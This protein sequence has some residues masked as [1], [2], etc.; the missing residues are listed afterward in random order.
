LQLPRALVIPS[1]W[2]EVAQ[3]VLVVVQLQE[4]LA[5]T[6]CLALLPVTVVAGAD[7]VAPAVAAADR[8]LMA[9]LVV[10]VV[11]EVVVSAMQVQ[12]ILLL[13]HPVKVTMVEQVQQTPQVVQVVVV[14]VLWVL[15]LLQLVE[16]TE[17]TVRLVA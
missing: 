9:W 1:Q 3:P 8:V 12:A 11:A 4:V 5:A 14:Q 6:V 10:V 17:A 15:Q 16:P 2:V 7:L 13:P